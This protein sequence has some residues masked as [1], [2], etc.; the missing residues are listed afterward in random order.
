VG[1]V[2]YYVTW[3]AEK[4]NG[5]IISDRYMH[6][7]SRKTFPAGLARDIDRAADTFEFDPALFYDLSVPIPEGPFF[8]TAE[9]ILRGSQKRDHEVTEM[10]VRYYQA[11]HPD[12][13]MVY[14]RGTD[15]VS[16]YYWKYAFPGDYRDTEIGLEGIERYRETIDKFYIYTDQLVGKILS[17]LAPDTTV[18]IASDHG[19]ETDRRNLVSPKLDRVLEKMGLLAFSDPEKKTINWKRTVA[20]DGDFRPMVMENRALNIN[21]A[22]REPSGRVPADKHEKRIK[23]VMNMLYRVTG[24]NSGK[25][26]F[27]VRKAE[28]D[29]ADLEVTVHFKDFPDDEIVIKNKVYPL[30][31]FFE[32]SPISG[33]HGNAPDGVIIV[34]GPGIEGSTDINRN[35]MLLGEAVPK[36][37]VMDIAPTILYTMGLPV[38]EDMDGR[39]LANAFTRGH[40]EANPIAMIPS[41]Q[42]FIRMAS[43]AAVKS[44]ADEEIKNQLRDLGYI[45]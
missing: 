42:V 23:T 27:S 44:G 19:F 32:V 4:V 30:D 1:V 29:T 25:P 10:A 38:G 31:D 45:N 5:F 41:Y 6:E 2:A 15:S 33:T 35:G 26:L 8:E 18:I 24:L 34:S 40:L 37:N 39:V 7:I 36:A 17:V 12:L 16:H 13:L 28:N 9:E 3:P 20:Y 22:G 11:Y 21:L 43:E 14:L